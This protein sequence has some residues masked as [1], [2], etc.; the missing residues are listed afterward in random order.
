MERIQVE[1]ADM[2]EYITKLE[3]IIGQQRNYMV[4]EDKMEA[5]LA[6]GECHPEDESVR[7]SLLEYK[8]MEEDGSIPEAATALL[9]ETRESLKNPMNFYTFGIELNLDQR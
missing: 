5:D 1:K 2:K 6:E 8:S 3:L 4:V 9:K 7:K